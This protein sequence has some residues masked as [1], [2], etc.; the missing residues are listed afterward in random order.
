MSDKKNTKPI[1]PWE[2]SELEK[3]LL[4]LIAHGAET[5]KIDFKVEMVQK[6]WNHIES[7]IFETYELLEG[8]KTIRKNLE[9]GP[10]VV[11]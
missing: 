7:Y 5:A 8:F 9:I 4:E 1:L 3:M 10:V 11:T 6:S 2:N